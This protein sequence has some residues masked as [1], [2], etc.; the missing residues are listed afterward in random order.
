MK[1]NIEHFQIRRLES[2][3]F[4]LLHAIGSIH[5]Y[6]SGQVL[7]SL[8]F[9]FD[10]SLTQ[11]DSLD[12]VISVHREYLDKVHKHCLLTEEFE[13]LMTTVNNLIEMC[14]HIRDRWDYNKLLHTVTE[15]SLMESSYIKYHTYLALTLHNTIQHKDADYLVG[16]SS[17]FNCSMPSI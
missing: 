10:Q 12:G 9:M 13:D 17:A 6:L 2:L 16:L 1:N 11:A 8:G 14:V 7:Q 3:R 15:L 4:W 5:A